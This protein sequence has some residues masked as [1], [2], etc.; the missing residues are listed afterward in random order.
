[1]IVSSLSLFQNAK[2][3]IHRQCNSVIVDIERVVL[4]STVVRII[5]VWY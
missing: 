3:R 4:L 5:A 1:M 2:Y